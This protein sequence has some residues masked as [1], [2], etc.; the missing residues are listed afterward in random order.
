MPAIIAHRWPT[1]AR[2]L[3]WST[4]VHAP[5]LLWVRLAVARGNLIAMAAFDPDATGQD[6]GFRLLA[7]TA[8]TLFWRADLLAEATLWLAEHGYQVIQLGSSPWAAEADFHRDMKTALDFPDYYGHNLDALND[9][10]RDVVNHRYGWSPDAT[11][12]VLAFT[13][14][15]RFALS[16]PRAAQIV[17]DIIACQSRSASLLGRRLIC[18]VQ[19]E[20]P[21][22][23][24]EPVGATPVLW[25]DA[26][27]LDSRRRTKGVET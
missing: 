14:Y 15:D 20:D 8:V 24:F 21:Q 12:L 23:R 2:R 18:L 5:T 1:L 9:C 19:S 25:N 6:L 3:V 13:A 16:C 17:L 11:G 27:W 26:E 22:I 4:V 7:N 10:L